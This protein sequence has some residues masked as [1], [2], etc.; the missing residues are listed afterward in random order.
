VKTSRVLL[1]WLAL[2][3]SG[4]AGVHADAEGNGDV[5]LPA[6]EQFVLPNGAR[7]ALLEKHDTP[8]VA[9]TALLRGG[10]L[11]DAP[12]Q[13]GTASLAAEMLQKGAG[14][15]DAASFAAALENV[16]AEL[17]IGASTEALVASASF[18]AKDQDLVLALLAD[19][20]QRPRLDPAEFEKLRTRSI[21]SILAAKDADPRQLVGIY[22]DAWLFGEHPYGRSSG[23]SEAT[24]QSIQVEDVR[25]YL[26]QQTGG[27]R[28]ILA[29][30]GDISPAGMRQRLER[31]FGTWRR[32]SSPPPE[33]SPARPTEGRHVLLVDKPGATQTYFW[34]GNVGRSRLDP[35]R[36]VQTLVNTVFGGRFTSMLNSELRI[37][38]GLTYGA[39]SGFDRLTQPGAFGMMSY[40][41]TESTVQAVDLTLQTL[42]RLHR[43][44]LTP[45]MV[46]SAR[47]YLLGQF[48]PTI[49]TNG[50]LARRIADLTFYGLG[51]EDVDGFAS[52]LRALDAQ[53]ANRAIGSAF[54]TSDDL[55]IVLLGDADRI[56]EDVRRYG[57]VTEMSL[58]DPRFHPAKVAE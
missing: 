43:E 2:S 15:R 9:V 57:P 27:D 36:D 16:G 39:R 17:Q 33:V 21:Q 11:G 52:R 46:D 50:Q 55:A 34:L 41:S 20:L 19:A 32:A 48:P 54:P 4:A 56:R 49:E 31:E 37:K 5:R 6:F 7:V 3:L 30:V 8:L 44:G 58:A 42:E 13:D 45:D 26:E 1:A 38:S 47:N 22:G 23:G 53:D 28:L 51:P 40:T 14:G 25:R 12:G 29:V 10:A 24:L 18:L 35:G